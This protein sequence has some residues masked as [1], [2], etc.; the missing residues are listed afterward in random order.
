[1]IT[2]GDE[3]FQLNQQVEFIIVFENFKTKYAQIKVCTG[4]IQA[5]HREPTLE[6]G[7]DFVKSLQGQMFKNMGVGIPLS[8]VIGYDIQT[9]SPLP[10]ENGEIPLYYVVRGSKGAPVPLSLYIPRRHVIRG[11]TEGA[12]LDENIGLILNTFFRRA[13]Y[14]WLVLH[15]AHHEP[16][17][18]DTSIYG[19]GGGG[20]GGGDN[21]VFL[22]RG[23]VVG[24]GSH[25]ILRRPQQLS[26]KT[27]RLV[28][29]VVDFGVDYDG[30][31]KVVCRLANTVNNDDGGKEKTS[32]DA[33]MLSHLDH[34]DTQLFHGSFAEVAKRYS[35]EHLF[36]LPYTA[37]HGAFDQ[38]TL[39]PQ[40]YYSVVKHLICDKL[41]RFRVKVV[42][43]KGAPSAPLEPLQLKDSKKK[44]NFYYG[45]TQD[46]FHFS[47]TGYRTLNLE[48]PPI[49]AEDSVPL[50]ALRVKGP[51]GTPCPFPVRRGYVIYGRIIECGNGRTTLEWCNP[52]YG[53]DLLRV[54]LATEG[55]SPIFQ[56]LSTSEILEKMKNNGEETIASKLFLGLIDLNARNDAIDYV[57]K[58]LIW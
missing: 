51:Y 5:I 58:E 35:S 23:E 36:K 53:V 4:E 43:V 26:R 22:E 25:K 55:N 45:F 27:R 21:Q 3:K 33:I 11:V 39:G 38:V 24:E 7:T 49:S 17:P 46:G 9:S 2:P 40:T 1:M 54:Y 8:R 34:L 37:I 14:G 32:N 20:G 28:G 30:V 47:A 50:G 41:Q 42:K 15:N 52:P 13:P 18:L 56:G 57:Y 48:I 6:L 16:K 31:I 44:D 10:W 29:E 19:G 12:S